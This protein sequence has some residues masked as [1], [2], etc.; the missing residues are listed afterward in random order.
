MTIAL[1]FA[2]GEGMLFGAGYDTM[3]LSAHAKLFPKIVMLDKNLEKKLIEGKVRIVI[4]SGSK[5]VQAAQELKSMI[6]TGYQGKLMQYS[7]NV[8]TVDVAALNDAN[9]A[10]AYYL[11][12][13]SDAQIQKVLKIA[14]KGNSM[15]FAY[16]INALSEGVLISVRVETRT[17]IYFNRAA[18]NPDA[19]PLRAEFFKVARAYE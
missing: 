5:D 18:W 19:L 13:L 17:T 12:S 14:K 4:V 2:I 9:E 11:L 3:L 6:A 10:S 8:E 15:T 1:M 16:D 7:L